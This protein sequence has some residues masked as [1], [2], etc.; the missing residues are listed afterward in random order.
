MYG[1]AG[2]SEGGGVGGASS[3]GSLASTWTSVC[4]VSVAEGFNSSS[5]SSP[6]PS[7]RGFSD[8]SRSS[9]GLDWFE[10]IIEAASL[11]RSLW[12]TEGRLG[13]R[14]GEPQLSR[15]KG[16]TDFGFGADG[17]ASINVN[18]VRTPSRI[19]GYK[20]GIIQVKPKSNPVGVIAR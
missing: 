13:E 17:G 1:L 9:G 20:G 5:E 15:W 6:S 2:R 12:P 7:R 10:A 3:L 19:Y 18:T 14:N 4:P 11:S 16:K 8:V